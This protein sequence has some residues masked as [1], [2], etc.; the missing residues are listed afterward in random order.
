M[1][2]DITDGAATGWKS[3]QNMQMVGVTQMVS[4][5]EQF[6]AALV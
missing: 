5:V 2:D 6:E 3:G 4:P 1:M